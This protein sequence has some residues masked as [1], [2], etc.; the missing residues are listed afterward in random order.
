MK[1]LLLWFVL[2]VLLLA[3]A[4]TFVLTRLDTGFVATTISDAVNKATGAPVTFTDQP[5]LSLFPL[6]VDFGRLAWKR[7]GPDRSLTVSAA[8]GHA[9]VA[10]S[11][12]FSA[13]GI[14]PELTRLVVVRPL[15]GNGSLAILGEMIEQYGADSYVAR[16][17][18]AVA[19]AGETTFYVAAIYFST[20]RESKLRYAVPVALIASLVGAVTACALV[21]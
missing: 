14:P 1:R 7:E 15:S 2:I 4:G 12:L 20:V 16:C 19:G 10:L 9:R 17:A 5:R 11:P 3:G 21:R 13:L 8:G 6:G 18:C